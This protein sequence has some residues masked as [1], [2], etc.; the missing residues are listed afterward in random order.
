MLL[1]SVPIFHNVYPNALV[2]F[3]LVNIK[4]PNFFSSF[5]LTKIAVAK[6]DTRSVRFSAIERGAISIKYRSVPRAYSI[7]GNQS[8]S[9]V[10]MLNFIN[11]LIIT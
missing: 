1:K 9:T 4:L 2:R 7:I 6:F 10:I 11:I 5:C 8:A 3:F